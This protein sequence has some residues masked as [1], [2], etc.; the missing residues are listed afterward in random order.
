VTSGDGRTVT[1]ARDW[2]GVPGDICI[3]A[4]EMT[5]VLQAQH[6]LPRG[7]AVLEPPAYRVQQICSTLAGDTN[8]AAYFASRVIAPVCFE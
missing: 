4:H 3:L 2:T 8:G 5:H 6:H 1:L 7:C